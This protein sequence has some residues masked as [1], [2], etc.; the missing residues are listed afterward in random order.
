MALIYDTRGENPSP[1]RPCGKQTNKQT[2]TCGSLICSCIFSPNIMPGAWKV[3]PKCR[4]G[5]I[6]LQLPELSSLCARPAGS[7]PDSCD[8]LRQVCLQPALLPPIFFHLGV[9]EL[10]AKR[11]F[12]PVFVLLLSRNDFY[13]FLTGG[14]K[15]KLKRKICDVKMTWNLHLTVVK[16]SFIGTQTLPPVHRWSLAAFT[17]EEPS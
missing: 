4:L 12:P 9:G 16:Y 2:K 13:I 1:A 6:Y 10:Q 8:G 11:G 5:G 3:L 17:L 7:L 15:K 14:E